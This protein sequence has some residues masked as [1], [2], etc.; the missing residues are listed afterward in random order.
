MPPKKS[1]YAASVGLPRRTPRTAARKTNPNPN[2]NPK[3]KTPAKS[4]T[5]SSLIATTTAIPSPPIASSPLT[6]SSPSSSNI[7]KSTTPPLASP[8]TELQKLNLTTSTTTTTTTTG[9]VVVSEGDNQN[10]KSTELNFNPKSTPTE[11]NLNPK[12]TTAE[13]DVSVDDPQSVIVSSQT[14]PTTTTGDAGIKEAIFADETMVEKVPVATAVAVEAKSIAES[15]VEMA[16]QEVGM[17]KTVIKKTV[18]V[19]KKVV[20][21]K[22]PKRV[23]K[24]QI[25]SSKKEPQNLESSNDCGRP[26]PTSVTLNDVDIKSLPGPNA[27][28]SNSMEVGKHDPVDT[29]P[30][31]TLK[32][33]VIVPMD[34]DNSGSNSGVLDSMEVENPSC[35]VDVPV[36]SENKKDFEACEGQK[37]A[38]VT[39]NLSE[40]RVVDSG[41]NKSEN[42]SEAAV[43][44]FG[45]NKNDNLP[46]AAVSDLVGNKNDGGMNTSVALEDQNII[47]VEPQNETECNTK[48]VKMESGEVVDEMKENETEH[49]NFASLEDR[50][51]LREEVA[52]DKKVVHGLKGEVGLSDRVLLSGELEA[53]ERRRRRKTE[54]FVGGLDKDTKEEDIRKVFEEVGEVTE[55]RLALNGKTGKNK[56]FAF[57]RFASAVDAKNAL[58]KFQKVEICGKQCGTSAVEGNDTLFLGNINKKWKT[59]DVV[60]LLREMGI[61]KIDKV[62]V[63][64]DPNKIEFNRG[65]AFVELE[66]YKDAQNAYNK[67]QKKDLLGKHWKINVAWAEPLI[68]PDEG[69]M[70]KVKSVYAEYLP[71]SWDEEKVTDYFKKFGEIENVALARNL[72][73]SKRKDFAFVNFTTREAALACIEAFSRD[74]LNDQDSKV[75]VKVSLA[76]PIPKAKQIKHVPNPTSK[77]FPK[78]KRKASQTFIRPHESRNKGNATSSNY[79]DVR[80]DSRSSTTSE[81]VQLL[82]E[83]ASWRQPEPGPGQ[84]PADMDQTYPSPGRKRPFSIMGDDMRYSDPRGCPR[85][86]FGTFPSANPSAFPQGIGMQGLP[87]HHQQGAGYTSEP[88]Y[89]GDGY[90]NYLQ[91][92]EPPPP[93]HGSNGVYRRY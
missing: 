86:R 28:V 18:R 67:L 37:D 11:L 69:E 23:L 79:G 32:A 4:T 27:S 9:E 29:I 75:N 43:S 38:S 84:G 71:S 19:V 40:D 6:S 36:N 74:Q 25:A 14:N 78:E 7:N 24:E 50:E 34:S 15:G 5:K 77:E 10:P 62:T 26:N 42:L 53:L 88:F 1:P 48:D 92:R 85:P 46:E 49:L 39:D 31:E 72:R 80:V 41:G 58:T 12:S 16:A 59:E 57:L 30:P 64:A 22:V 87:H 21:K 33:N 83:Q 81:L 89:R 45:E 70:L 52:D 91:R 51:G 35:V 8:Q 44:D 63:M 54:I 3:P 17:K 55:V 68:E 82:R 76:K 56:G 93:Y 2:P 90:P 61:E 13:E 47:S 73:S 65:F 20:K 66:T 60:K